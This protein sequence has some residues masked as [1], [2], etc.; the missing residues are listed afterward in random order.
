MYPAFLFA[1][2]PSFSPKVGGVFAPRFRLPFQ[3]GVGV[4][5][6]VEPCLG[7]A[8]EVEDGGIGRGRCELR[9]TVTL[10]DPRNGVAAVGVD[11]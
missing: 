6:G 3:D 10:L 8:D 2:A 7:P 1:Y 9:T 5:V 11:R 4:G